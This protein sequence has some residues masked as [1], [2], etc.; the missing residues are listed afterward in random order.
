VGS[1]IEPPSSGNGKRAS[2]ST[3]RE[4]TE[5][6]RK[7]LQVVYDEARAKAAQRR[8]GSAEQVDDPHHAA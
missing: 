6:L 3:L 5:E 2:R 1:P 7:E 4:L 8:A